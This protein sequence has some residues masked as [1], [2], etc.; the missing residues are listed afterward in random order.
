MENYK[1][2]IH[3]FPNSK[4]YIGIT[5]Q[6]V[7]K[8]W[9]NGLGYQTQKLLFKAIKKYGWKNIEHIVLFNNLNENKAKDFEVKFIKIFKSNKIK[10]GYNISN[11]GDGK[12]SVSELTRKKLSKSLKGKTG[13]KW[14]NEEKQRASERYKNREF[15]E[16]WKRKISQSKQG[17]KNAMYGKKLTQE[18]KDKISKSVMKNSKKRKVYCFETDTIY[19][20]LSECGRQLGIE[21]SKISMVCKGKRNHTKNYHFKYV[22]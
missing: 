19:I 1:V 6:D 15:T 8:R 3:I 10:Y 22:D 2:Y 9:K 12:F 17:S 13:H 21:N 20:S 11:G 16:E 4:V 18:Q 7:E 14:T 5:K